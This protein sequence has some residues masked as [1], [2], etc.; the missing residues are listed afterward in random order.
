MDDIQ[1][2]D[3]NPAEQKCFRSDFVQRQ[4]RNSPACLRPCIKYIAEIA[5]DC[6]QRIS[7]AVTRDAGFIEIVET[8]KLVDSMNMIGVTV[9]VKDAM[10]FFDVMRQALLTKVCRRVYEYMTAFIL[11]QDRGSKAAVSQVV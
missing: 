5:F 8:A 2:R 6:R 7:T 11:Y 3:G 1:G 4:L 10:D 9:R